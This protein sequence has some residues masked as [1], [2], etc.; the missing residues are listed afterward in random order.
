MLLNLKNLL[1][2]F[3]V[4]L[5]MYKMCTVIHNISCFPVN[6]SDFRGWLGVCI[7][8]WRQM[9]RVCKTSLFNQKN[10]GILGIIH[11]EH[12]KLR[13]SVRNWRWIR[14][15]TSGCQRWVVLVVSRFRDRGILICRA[16][17]YNNQQHVSWQLITSHSSV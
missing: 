8:I 13:K 15:W 12:E 7:S 4:I 5:I 17:A 11:S 10:F 14:L 2:F 16:T 1:Y 6:D 9:H 3:S